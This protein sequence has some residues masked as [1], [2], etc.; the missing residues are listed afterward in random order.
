MQM[1][2]KNSFIAVRQVGKY[3]RRGDGSIWYRQDPRTIQ[4]I[5]GDS[6]F[7]PSAAS[8]TVGPAAS[9]GH[10]WATRPVAWY[11]DRTRSKILTVAA[12]RSNT[13]P[14]LHELQQ[15][16]TTIEAE[17]ATYTAL[18]SVLASLPNL[19]YIDEQGC[20]TKRSDGTFD[21]SYVTKNAYTA[22][23]SDASGDTGYMVMARAPQWPVD[24]NDDI[25]TGVT[26]PFGTAVT[27]TPGVGP[28]ADS[29]TGSAFR[30]SHVYRPD[31]G[32]W[33]VGWTE[34][35]RFHTIDA[36]ANFYLH[37][38]I[39]PGEPDGSGGWTW[40]T[41]VEITSSGGGNVPRQNMGEGS[42]NQDFLYRLSD[43]TWVFNCQLTGGGVG[44]YCRGLKLD[45][46][47]TWTAT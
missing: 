23:P 30:G 38:K 2:W 26:Y 37:P 29:W 41:P 4:I 45:G 14:N 35:Q 32:I 3:Y 47:G 7:L 9:A 46:T 42:E 1:I 16:I 8:I 44:L 21:L 40:G 12:H 34:L 20:L 36:K 13:S 17:S 15:F 6:L 27:Y 11:V 25:W 22:Y 19:N 43:G 33:A 24:G 5:R 28:A 39:V 18:G 10:T 31:G